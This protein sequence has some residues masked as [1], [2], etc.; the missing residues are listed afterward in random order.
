MKKY[1]LLF[2]VNITI[3]LSFISCTNSTLQEFPIDTVADENK[4][5]IRTDST[6]VSNDTIEDGIIYEIHIPEKVEYGKIYDDGTMYFE[7]KRASEEDLCEDYFDAAFSGKTEICESLKRAVFGK[8]TVVELKAIPD[9]ERCYYQALSVTAFNQ[10]I[11]LSEE[12]ILMYT[13]QIFGIYE[14]EDKTV[15]WITK[16][17]NMGEKFDIFRMWVIGYDGIYYT[18]SEEEEFG[19]T[20]EY[21]C[22]KYY[23][24]TTEN[25]ELRY[26]RILNKYSDLQLLGAELIYCVAQDEFCYENGTVSFDGVIPI[27]SP[28]E[29]YTVQ[30]VYDLEKSY[31]N[32]RQTISHSNPK[33]QS[34]E[35]LLNYNSSVYVKGK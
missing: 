30:D 3:V 26:K 15:I 20:E 9:G 19:G 25:G 22:S 33:I 21:N 8:N 10:R 28:D 31:S 32:Y 17:F 6:T 1:I 5:D 18:D 35:Q 23:F 14:L 34:L 29:I 16:P 13:H 7:H 27:Y 12:Y 4:E 11:D 2:L 24:S